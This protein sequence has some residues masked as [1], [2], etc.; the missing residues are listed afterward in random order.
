MGFA[1]VAGL[2]TITP[3]LDTVLVL[4]ASIADGRRAGY[5]TAAGICLGL[6]AWG[7]AAAIGVSALLATSQLAYD[8]LRYAGA[9]YLVFLGAKLIWQRRSSRSGTEPDTD[10]AE[11]PDLPPA[12]PLR[13]HFLR[14]LLTNL[15]NPKIGVFYVAVLPQFLPAGTPGA[16]SGLALASVHVLESLVWFSL[17][18]LGSQMLRA[19]LRRPSVQ[20]WTDRVAG[21][22]LIG[23]GVTVAW[24]RS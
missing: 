5:A 20:A 15:L 2:M 16:L 11:V 1:V 4:R 3:G 6:L 22:V 13:R 17:L 23:F 14:G 12:T 21:G 7:V 18:I 8:V 24:G 10:A 9:A 19:T